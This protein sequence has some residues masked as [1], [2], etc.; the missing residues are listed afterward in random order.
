MKIA[1]IADPLDNQ[2]AGVHV[3]TK[4]MVEALIAHKTEHNYI[5]V[6]QKRDVD[7]SENIPQIVIPNLRFIPLFAS[8]RLFFLIPLILR[9][10]RVDVVIEPAH[11]GPFNLPKSIRR[12]TV[13]HDVTPL[14]FPQYHRWHGQIL[15]RLFL[16]RILKKTHLILTVSQHTAKDIRRIFPFTNPKIKV[17]PLGRDLSFSP[18]PDQ[19]VLDKW[20]IK[21]PYFISVGTI[22]P[23]KNLLVLLDAYQQFR[24]QNESAVA[25]LIVGGKG[26]K[27]QSFYDKLAQHAYRNDIYL[28]G[29]VDKADLPV[30]YTHA[31]AL[32]YPSLYEGFGLPVLEAMTCGTVIICSNR[33]S[34]P[35]V[36][37]TAALYFDPENTL[38][39]LEHLHSIAT[40][41]KLS[42]QRQ[43]L[44][45]Q[46]A[47]TFSWKQYAQSFGE[48]LLCIKQ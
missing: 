1:I 34:L 18:T 48:V 8:F 24:D 29:Y 7:L 6:R 43:V 38:E 9:L 11:F 30:L 40:N 15:Q 27:Y 25:L 22:E 46:Q 35:E 21:T 5:L 26:W 17:I 44:S 4:G 42:A 36:G 23:R 28:L 14:L 16:K 33:S 47:V 45:L 41:G 3:Y 39:L 31:L 37:G 19:S 32:I 12:I 2:S 10:L 13:I 20:Q